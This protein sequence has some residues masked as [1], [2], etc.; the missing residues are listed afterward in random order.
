MTVEESQQSYQ[1][2]FDSTSKETRCDIEY[3]LHR[4]VTLMRHFTN[5]L[6]Q[7]MARTR[8]KRKQKLA[9]EQCGFVEGKGKRNLIYITRTRAL[10]EPKDTYICFIEYTVAFD[11]VCHEKNHINTGVFEH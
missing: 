7:I 9:G 10:E 2:P 4:V 11:I 6:L 1:D 3:E 5:M 8:N